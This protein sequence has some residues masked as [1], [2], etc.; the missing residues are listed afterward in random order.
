MA[1]SAG[2]ASMEHVAASIDLRDAQTRRDQL[3]TRACC[4]SSRW[5]ERMVARRPFGSR[6]ALAP[7]GGHGMEWHALGRE[8]TGGRRSAQHPK[9]G[10]REAAAA[11]AFLRRTQLSARE[12][13]GASAA[14]RRLCSTRSPRATAGTRRRFGYIFIVCATGQQCGGDARHC[15]TARL[16]KRRGAPS[17]ESPPRSRRRSSRCGLVSAAAPLSMSL[18]R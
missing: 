2:C 13:A 17:S 10:D 9:I 11:S 7:D 18:S 6:E 5:V 15:W 14:R 12:Q 8:L 4:A 16:G 1:A 3:L